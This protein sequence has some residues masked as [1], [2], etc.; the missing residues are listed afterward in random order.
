MDVVF[1]FFVSMIRTFEK[2]VIS[3]HVPYKGVEITLLLAR[4]YV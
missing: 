1:L 4:T 2:L 3:A